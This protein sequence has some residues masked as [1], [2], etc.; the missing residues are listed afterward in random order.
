[1]NNI[2]YWIKW[3]WAKCEWLKSPDENATTPV[4]LFI[5]LFY[6]SNFPYFQI[7]HSEHKIW[8]WSCVARVSETGIMPD[9]PNAAWW[10]SSYIAFHFFSMNMCLRI[11]TFMIQF[12]ACRLPSVE[13]ENGDVAAPLK[14]KLDDERKAQCSPFVHILSLSSFYHLSNA[15]ADVFCV[16]LRKEQ[17][18]N[19]E[20]R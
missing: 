6:L 17:A 19:R 2:R 15:L 8:M 1:M 9:L 12:V 18:Q 5:Q 10:K 16:F 3:Q 11:A 14:S 13:S 7:N 20:S 4:N